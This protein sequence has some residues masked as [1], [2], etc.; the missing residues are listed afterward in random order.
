M[1]VVLYN[2]LMPITT[3]LD[4]L[5]PL[6][7]LDLD[8][9]LSVLL[10]DLLNTGSVDSDNI[11]K[12]ISGTYTDNADY[13]KWY[14]VH[15]KQLTFTEIFRL[16]DIYFGT[17][18]AG[19]PL[20]TEGIASIGASP[21]AFESATGETGYRS[22]INA[23]DGLTVI[24]SALLEVVDFSSEKTGGKTNGEIV[25]AFI[26]E[27]SG[28]TKAS[29]ILA[30][31]K[32]LF[33]GEKID[34]E[35]INWLYFRSDPDAGD[36]AETDDLSKVTLPVKTIEYLK[37]SNNWNKPT[38]DSLTSALSGI[39]DKVL[40]SQ[41]GSDLATLLGGLLTDNVYTDD[42]LDSLVEAV[43]KA[44]NGIDKALRETVMLMLDVE[45]DIINTWFD[46]CDIDSE[47]GEVT[48]T[49]EWNINGD[50]DAF[51]AALEEVFTPVH[52]LL[53]WLLFGDSYTFFTSSETEDGKHTLTPIIGLVGNENGYAYG[54]VPL[55]EALGCDM[56]APEKYKNAD[57]TSDMT[58]FV[59]DLLVSVFDRVDELTSGKP[60][61][62]IIDLLPNL[63]Y[64]INADGVK[65]T[66]NNLLAPVI[67]IL[68]KLT[69][70]IGDASLNDT[71]GFE[72]D[73]LTTETLFAIL[74][75]KAGITV[76]ESLRGII[77]YLYIGQLNYFESANGEGALNMCYAPDATE[78]EKTS[79]RAD[80]ITVL[81]SV[82]LD[83]LG[84]PNNGDTFTDMLGEETYKAIYD[85]LNLT[86]P[87]FRRDIDWLYTEYADNAD[88]VFSGLETS[89][90]FEYGYGQYWTKDKAEYIAK[91]IGCFADDLIE[92]LGIEVD[93]KQLSSLE[94]VLKSLVGGTIYTKS[95]LDKIYAQITKLLANTDE[96]D[97]A[98]LIKSAVKSSL[99]VDLKFYDSYT[100]SEFDDGDRDA[101]TEGLCDM[102]SPL[103]PLLSWLLTERDIAFFVD[104]EGKDQV[105]LPGSDGY[106]DGIIPVLEALGCDS[107]ADYETY[108]ADIAANEDAMLTDILNPV[109]DKIDAILADPANEIF[110]L[111]P[112]VAY[113]V[114]SNGLDSVWKNTLNSVY[115]VLDAIE[116]LVHVDLYELIGIKLDE[117]T[118]ESLYRLALSKAEESTGFDFAEL[119]FDAV[120]ELTTGKLVSFTSLNGR[121]A[122]RMEY[123]GMADRADTVTI[124]LRLLLK[125]IGTEDN[126]EKIEAVIKEET[127]MDENAYKFVCTF[128]EQFS[129]MVSTPDGMD[130]ALYT[131]YYVFY[132]IHVGAHTGNDWHKQFN[133]N[134]QFFFQLL[135]KSDVEFIRNISSSV[136]DIMDSLTKD[137]IDSDGLASSGLI[138]FFKKIAEMFKKL[139]EMLSN[140]FGK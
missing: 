63:V 133:S 125:F 107:I 4:T 131:V 32:S 74:K 85:V 91:Y 102:L 42:V 47:T 65:A 38:A 8:K 57:G 21:D 115:T 45:P 71:V 66:V 80:T 67:G 36:I 20:V 126:V 88:K 19:S 112:N 113:F 137:V 10:S 103:Y 116:P 76:S 94:D 26:D 109:F 9:I 93:G 69:P 34:A 29:D 58:E 18:I 129:Q 43:V 75:E 24:L 130:K 139:F 114:N 14:D 23:A 100:V 64:F 119:T 59:H 127:S 101:F 25:C 27:K 104:S 121:K 31:V 110:E 22:S 16:V 12:V 98:E 30:L 61:E 39:V 50:K 97:E 40:V 3:L 7:D 89:K 84:D 87:E 13:E 54:I 105:V 118:F 41:N 51:I 44:L 108:L 46:M 136:K 60:L 1:S 140:L 53:A 52:K 92:F 134:W 33:T 62:N 73:N 5:R 81:L 37:Y 55:L 111:L 95:N 132:G 78:E 77:K 17:D 79:F 122:Y 2:I 120:A 138:K 72:L 6:V 135:D 83:I 15:T 82:A 117:M 11:L 96:L 128:I 106:N 86:V 123:A 49:R 68:T 124:I 48:C 35:K 90:L 70:V 56:N 28:N 99:G